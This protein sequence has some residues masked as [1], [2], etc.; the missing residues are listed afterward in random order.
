MSR[1]RSEG[2]PFFV[3]YHHTQPSGRGRSP[4]R[5]MD[6][7]AGSATGP[8]RIPGERRGRGS[9]PRRSGNR[10][11]RSDTA[12][13]ANRRALPDRAGS[14]PG[15]LRAQASRAS[16]RRDVGRS[17]A[18]RLCP[19]EHLCHLGHQILRLGAPHGLASHQDDIE[20]AVDLRRY[21]GPGLAQDPPSPVP[22]DGASHPTGSDHGDPTRAGREKHYH[23]V[24]VRRPAFGE[25]LA[26]LSISHGRCSDREPGPALAPTS[27][28]DGAAGPRPHA[29]AEP[30]ALVPAPVVRLKRALPLGHVFDPIAHEGRHE[31]GHAAEYT[32]GGRDRTKNAASEAL[33]TKRVSR[34]PRAAVVWKTSVLLCAPPPPG[35]IEVPTAD[36]AR[37]ISLVRF[38]TTV[39]R[40][41]G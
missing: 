9:P 27:G 26:D 34:P 15:E 36:R 29:K 23:P 1:E 5:R 4:P 21:L 31:A 18:R 14:P 25:D 17:R 19:S 32:V 13:R 10:W 37:R 2:R 40:L 24:S 41:C 8:S 12:R 3:G 20:T 11:G 35:A 7:S 16:R 33:T 6:C 28:Q 22:L 38:S 39:E 30:M